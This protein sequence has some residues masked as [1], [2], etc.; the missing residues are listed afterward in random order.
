M[1]RLQSPRG[2]G[3]AAQRDISG[4]QSSSASATGMTSW[5]PRGGHSLSHG[6]L[7]GNNAAPPARAV[8]S[9]S[10][11]DR[12]QQRQQSSESA[13]QQPAAKAAPSSGSSSLRDRLQQRQGNETAT[14]SM[15]T[16]VPS[17][18]SQPHD[19]NQPRRGEYVA[20]LASPVS[21]AETQSQAFSTP[22]RLEASPSVGAASS[23]GMTAFAKLYTAS[24]L[25]GRMMRM[26]AYCPIAMVTVGI[27]ITVFVTVIGVVLFP[28]NIETSF[29][30]FLK[31]DVESSVIR[32]AFWAAY[33]SRSTGGSVDNRRLRVLDDAATSSVASEGTRLLDAREQQLTGLHLTDPYG[34][35]E[36][37]EPEDDS[38]SKPFRKAVLSWIAP[39]I[40]EET[41][42]G[43]AVSGLD[44]RR[45]QEQN[46]D[47][48][49]ATPSEAPK[50]YSSK[51]LFVAYELQG[52]GLF[53]GLF[54]M[55]ALIQ[56]G[57]FERKLRSLDAWTKLCGRVPEEYQELCK[58]GLSFVS[59]AMPT[60]DVVDGKVVPSRLL[61]DG[62]GSESVPLQTSLLLARR[63]G[64][65]S[66]LLPLSLN[67]SANESTSDV[68][69]TNVL[70][71]AFRFR[72]PIATVKDSATVRGQ[73]A[74]DFQAEWEAF[75]VDELMPVLKEG[76]GCETF[77]I[78]Y[79]GTAFH[80]LEVTSALR[81]DL[82]L[83]AASGVFVLL[84]VLFHTRSVLLGLVGVFLTIMSVPLSYVFSAMTLGTR[85]VSFTSFL[86][87][88][89]VVGFGSDVI[90]VYT[91]FWR[92][93]LQ[94]HDR[95]EDR[96]AWTYKHASR[97]SF[98]T[99]ATTALSFFANLASVIR[100]LRQFGFFMGTCVMIVWLLI[101]LIYA[102]LLMIDE[103]YFER[104][105]LVWKK[106]GEPLTAGGVEPVVEEGRRKWFGVW[107]RIVFRCR[108]CCCI[109]PIVAAMV[110]LV[111]AGLSVQVL[112][113]L[114]QL[115]P[116]DH[117]MNRG[118]QVFDLFDGKDEVFPSSFQMPETSEN[119]CNEQRF[120]ADDGSKCALYWCEARWS[121]DADPY[122]GSCL[123]HRKD[124]TTCTEPEAGG[125]RET[126]DFEVVQRFVSPK[127]LLRKTL[128]VA[129]VDYLTGAGSGGTTL[130]V[131]DKTSQ[132]S[133]LPPMIQQEWETGGVSVSHLTEVVVHMKIAESEASEDRCG[134][135]DLC[136]CGEYVCNLPSS[137]WKAAPRFELPGSYANDPYAPLRRAQ[138]EQPLETA[139]DVSEEATGGLL[140]PSV[141]PI[142]DGRRLV[143]RSKRAKVR[144][145]FGLVVPRTMPLLGES[146]DSQTLYSF[147]ENFDLRHPWAQRNLAHFCMDLPEHLK[148]TKS[149][150]WM[151]DFRTDMHSNNRRFPSLP[152]EFDEFA[153]LYVNSTLRPTR[154]DRYVWREGQSL[155][156]MYF[157]F[158]V[159]ILSDSA[160]DDAMK[161]KADWDAYLEEWNAEAVLSARGA[162]HV[163]STWV[164]A[165]ASGALLSSTM[166]TLLI[167][168]ILAFGG[169]LTFTW[170][171]TLSLYTVFATIGV[172]FG[173]A[174]FITVV[175]G[176]KVG[177]IE[178]IAII[179]FVGYAVTYSLHVAHKYASLTASSAAPVPELGL[180]DPTAALRFLRTDF[181]LKAIGGA[182]MGSA[183][184]TAGTSFFLIF[185]TL[186]IFTKLGGM[187]LAVTVMSIMAALG[188]LPAA[189]MVCGPRRPGGCSSCQ[190][191]RSDAE[192]GSGC[193]GL[194]SSR[195]GAK[196]T[197]R[198]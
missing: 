35:M 34:P 187:C 52:E 100:A 135:E 74:L 195:Q 18:L 55:E 31:T 160:T 162:F 185:C 43:P 106:K 176:W 177:L 141:R 186:T 189:L 136:F 194:L 152:A 127:E 184:T 64:V 17:Q 148:V 126:T 89:L 87:L 79:D 46:A 144:V 8:P 75:V 110:G 131:T 161:H 107:G 54:H 97:A 129:S 168:I 80:G 145:V 198:E 28:M 180:D 25:P 111:L 48:G 33:D 192:E 94:H 154:G 69:S 27:L 12:L 58:P 78:W 120:R 68:K 70:R 65:Y 143:P 71:S 19:A 138:A 72:I 53:G 157:S 183:I 86:A 104:Y 169:M 182:A 150:C 83:A 163:S 116:E 29:D 178:V 7:A 13:E 88:F 85:T 140:Q 42:S 137:T 142:I 188:P 133:S 3:G 139:D 134:W 40:G 101:T 61:L 82:A 92:D 119:V 22:R 32:D 173:L 6:P 109:L 170:S 102:P 123:C 21:A 172:I 63:H 125:E 60:A 37:D 30:S 15:S 190:K 165:E 81:S 67:V 47:D 98:A 132:A 51:D 99:T 76:C 146:E 151:T 114:P 197:P 66:T 103:Q 96:L 93:S 84:Y 45:L 171:V 26:P 121:L 155:R 91:D 90:F 11:R 167:L 174:F 16:P 115:F 153:M 130:Q 147:Y 196:T 44:T 62:R 113:G 112:E 149:W 124:R 4:S 56:V 118:V 14:P 156:S 5:S 1:Q 59:Y 49:E 73:G 57:N 159:N 95:Y 164:T 175:M 193:L 10:L 77:K 23:I 128:K 105:R 158:E 9:R 108:R 36:D 166:G 191:R 20:P 181:A 2:L 50:V 122:G 39:G 179:Y 41:G 117:N 38:R 24:S